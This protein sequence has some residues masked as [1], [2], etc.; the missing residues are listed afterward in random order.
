MKTKLLAIVL[1]ILCL[2]QPVAALGMV[3]VESANE[4]AISA[5]YVEETAEEAELSATTTFP[6]AAP[7][8]SIIYE[9]YESLDDG[10][11]PFGVA[12]TYNASTASKNTTLGNFYSST[13]AS[14]VVSLAGNSIEAVAAKGGKAFKLANRGNQWSLAGFQIDNLPAAKAGK[15]ILSFKTFTVYD[16]TTAWR[17]GVSMWWNGSTA[18]GYVNNNVE[19]WQTFTVAYEITVDGDTKTISSTGLNGNG[20]FTDTVSGDNLNKMEFRWINDS[21]ATEG[22]QT[23]YLD[24]L[25]VRYLGPATINYVDGEGAILKTVTGK[26]VADTITLATKA[27]LG[28]GYMPV[29]TI[30]GKTY[31]SGESVIV[32]SENM[33][34][35][36]EP[37]V[38]TTVVPA[39]AILYEDFETYE[40][41]TLAAGANATAFTYDYSGF[42]G[43]TLGNHYEPP[44]AYASLNG[45]MTWKQTANG[46]YSSGIIAKNLNITEIGKYRFCTDLYI[47]NAVSDGNITLTSAIEIDGTVNTSLYINTTYNTEADRNT[48]TEYAIDLEIYESN[49]K[50]YY[51]INNGAKTG[52]LT[53]A[54]TALG[55]FGYT[56]DAATKNR[57]LYYDNVVLTKSVPATITY[58]DESNTTLKTDSGFTGDTKSI[59]SASS[60]GI[61]YYPIYKINGETVKAGDTITLEGNVTVDV[62]KYVPENIPAGAILYED[63]EYYT[64]GHAF[65]TKGSAFSAGV[66]YTT[67]SATISNGTQVA[68]SAMEFRAVT[69]D[70]S[71][72]LEVS[73]LRGTYDTAGYWINAVNMSTEGTYRVS[74]DAKY[75]NTLAGN[76]SAATDTLSLRCVWGQSAIGMP[77]PYA[78][79]TNVTVFADWNWHELSYEYKVTKNADGTYNFVVTDMNGLSQPTSNVAAATAAAVPLQ[80]YFGVNADANLGAQTPVKVY[81]DN[82]KVTY[83]A[84]VIINASFETANGY[85]L[86]LTETAENTYTL[87]TAA[88]LGIAYE[89]EYTYNG[90]TYYPGETFT[91]TESTDA[92]FI[93]NKSEVVVYAD[94]DKY[95][96]A[97]T[98]L[99]ISPDYRIGEAA[100]ATVEKAQSGTYA[101]ATFDGK[102]VLKNTAAGEWGGGLAIKN[103]SFKEPGRYTIEF[104]VYAEIPENVTY[105]MFCTTIRNAANSEVIGHN[106]ADKILAGQ[107]TTWSYTV[108]VYEKDGALWIKEPTLDQN[109][110]LAD[111][112][113]PTYYFYTQTPGATSASPAAFYYDY[114]KVTYT[115]Y[116][117]ETVQKA[118]YRAPDAEMSQAGLRFAAYV[119]DTQKAAATE[120]GFVATRKAFLVEKDAVN[121]ED[122]LNL[123]DVTVSST[124][125]T[126]ASNKSGVRIVAGAAFKDGVNRIYTTDGK[127]F[128]EDYMGLTDIFFTGVLYGIPE[129]NEDEIFVARPYIKVDGVYYYGDC[130]ERSYNQVV[131]SATPVNE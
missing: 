35:N 63:F 33:T 113:I 98:E 110:E 81:V 29:Y 45:N 72:V 11:I 114:V 111:G 103:L 55:C 96:A 119:N 58:V 65:N 41:K 25:C 51:S 86:A 118:S 10:T 64:D 24:D 40:V 90:I 52:E 82:I 91:V 66:A 70:G 37:Y 126:A 76:A 38:S 115:P 69:V 48:R 21:V 112:Y 42:T 34:V 23:I 50:K 73:G 108:E 14:S 12:A 67:G 101:F 8:G 1:S 84:P 68:N 85:S 19:S 54:I 97:A 39:N 7:V 74:M 71:K 3:G 5:D 129:G 28:Q 26:N 46:N 88:E 107:W 15:Y 127:T 49:G 32:N 130:I 121:Y 109:K 125:T 105:K 104:N 16:G 62:S 4:T 75:V 83:A 131:N 9:D 93:V 117:P 102:K 123:E 92:K 80:Y 44:T 116:A 94:F 27:E 120:Y 60:L 95:N 99:S 106:F 122:Y 47:D 13:T 61:S 36:V 87:P 17:S 124:G 100:S 6:A 128:G 56:P 18:Y 89:P 30:D 22:A 43:V 79:G 78:G 59:L 2:V 31:R 77:T 53:G 57:N 20:T